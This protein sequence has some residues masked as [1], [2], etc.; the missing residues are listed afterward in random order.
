MPGTPPRHPPSKQGSGMY[1]FRPAL[2]VIVEGGFDRLCP[3]ETDVQHAPTAK[4]SRNL[5]EPMLAE[6]YCMYGA[7]IN[8]GQE[9]HSR[10]DIQSNSVPII[11]P[12]YSIHM[13][14]DGTAEIHQVSPAES[15][16]TDCS[17]R[18]TLQPLPD[19]VPAVPL[20]QACNLRVSNKT[21]F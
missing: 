20:F 5:T 2:C 10:A 18:V 9:G 19:T 6:C 12:I 3:S 16:K 14:C 1:P 7:T 13:A 11:L 4:S 21:H 17:P 15:E 8:A